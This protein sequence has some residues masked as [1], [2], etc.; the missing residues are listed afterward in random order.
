MNRANEEYILNDSR[1]KILVVDDREENLFS[2]ETIL[3]RDGYDI[4]KANSGKAA[5]KIL[6]KQHDFTLILMDVVMPDL[7]GFETATLIYERDLLKHIPI[8]FI[9]ANDSDEDNIFKGYK[10]G[11]VDYI[12]KPINPELLRA[13]VSVFAELYKKTH[14][15]IEQ[16]KILMSINRRLERE[17]RERKSSENR[18]LDLNEQL[19]QNI[20]QLQIS[21][22]ELERFAYV[23][24]HDLQ[25]PLRKIIFFTDLLSS[26]HKDQFAE[27]DWNYANRILKASSRMQAL[28][29]NILE[30]SRS[31]SLTDS[32]EEIEMR[33]ILEEVL[34]DLEVAIAEKQAVINIGE[35]PKVKVM[36]E[37]FK[38][39][40]QN[41]INNALKFSKDGIAPEIN[42]YS[43][44]MKGCNIESVSSDFYDNDYH[45]IC[46]K[47]NG[48]GFEQKYVNE[49]FTLFKR[50]HSKDQFEGSG[51]GLSICKKIVEKHHGFL[52]AKS[53]VG[54][55]A[56]FIISLPTV[57]FI[58]SIE[59]KEEL[60]TEN[61]QR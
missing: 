15:L 53:E 43:E 24:S 60:S 21:N 10:M 29:K 4:T 27:D 59:H 41:L 42:I 11:G 36:P 31:T 2:I 8:I 17:I 44:M 34:S 61:E 5:L 48:I 14:Q 25:E 51:I 32:M 54:E 7:N 56:T 33:I 12:R 18:V 1:V 57:D 26:K 13:K 30:F 19:L 39:L 50:L 16:E 37:L 49:I 55:G 46:I 47:D 23:A 22:E 28:I 52:T 40:F 45:N 58:N 35:L 6:L 38:Q 3:E 9:T 20:K